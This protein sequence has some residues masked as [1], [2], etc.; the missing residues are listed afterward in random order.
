MGP[1]S[2]D[3]GALLGLPAWTDAWR[4]G[5]LDLLAAAGD[6]G[7][8]PIRPRHDRAFHRRVP[9]L[10]AVWPAARCAGRDE[11]RLVDRPPGSRRF[12]DRRFGAHLLARLHHAGGV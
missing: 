4:P 2:A 11:A 1:R 7:H 9:A 8:R 6:R 5:P 10:P 12:P 3:V